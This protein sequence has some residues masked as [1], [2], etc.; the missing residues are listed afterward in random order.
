MVFSQRPQRF[1]NQNDNE[2]QLVVHE[3]P[4]ASQLNLKFLSG[5]FPVAMGVALSQ[6]YDLWLCGFT[7][8]CTSKPH[9]SANRF[10][11][12]FGPDP[13]ILW[14]KTASELNAT[15]F[16]GAPCMCHHAPFRLS[17]GLKAIN[18]VH[19]KKFWV[20]TGCHFHGHTFFM[21]PEITQNIFWVT[22]DIPMPLNAG[23]KPPHKY[24]FFQL[25]FGIRIK[26]STVSRPHGKHNLNG[27]TQPHASSASLRHQWKGAPNSFTKRVLRT[28]AL[29]TTGLHDNP[30]SAH[31]FASELF[32]HGRF[33]FIYM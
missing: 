19:R 2:P 6:C 17:E 29:P 8:S 11:A 28:E 10:A 12:C 16:S 13:T 21:Y 27:G 23:P 25:E 31:N 9:C 1:K 24:H 33:I 4:S 26:S 32:H 14:R 30:T 18:A 20:D 22:M 15:V 5:A 7:R 3:I